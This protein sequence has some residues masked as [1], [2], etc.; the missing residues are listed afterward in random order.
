MNVFRAI[1]D[2]FKQLSYVLTKGQKRMSIPIFF[3][4]VIGSFFEMLGVSAILPFIESLTSPDDIMNKW[5]T[6]WLVR[7]F[8]LDNYISIVIGLAICIVVIYIIKNKPNLTN[9]I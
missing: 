2:I 1:G 5:Y 3:M 9:A 6:I 4:I 7:I 8:N